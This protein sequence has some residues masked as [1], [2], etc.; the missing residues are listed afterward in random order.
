MENYLVIDFEATCSNDGSVRREEMEIIEIG[1][2]MVDAR[3]QQSVD[4]YQSFVR[5]VR[6]EFLTAFC[7]ELTSIRQHDVDNAL[8]FPEVL[9]DSVA[10]TQAYPSPLFCSWGNYDRHQLERD[11]EYHNAIYPFGDKHVNLKKKFAWANGRKPQGVRAAMKA[12]GLRFS[13][14]HHRGIDDARNIARLI[15]YIFPPM[16]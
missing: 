8:T 5:P 13:G 4:E 15:P 14:T 7:R 10:W 6:N 11:C 9:E 1:A 16:P 3:T 12:A 2:V